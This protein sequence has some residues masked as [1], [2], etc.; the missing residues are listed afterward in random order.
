MTEKEK[1][2]FEIQQKLRNISK[3]QSDAPAIIP[4]GIFSDE[5]KKAVT[6]FQKSHNLNQTGRVDFATFEELKRENE[7]VLFRESLPVQVM[8]IR[9]EDFPIS[10]GDEN[11]F[12]EKL[13]IM[14][15]LVA[16][17]HKNFSSL[18]RNSVFDRDTE[19]QVRKW[20][21]VTFTRETG[22]VD[23]ETWNSL[24]AYYLL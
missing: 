21:A 1:V 10:Y 17:R 22:V 16:D 4:D 13:K 24:A 18:E 3:G 9:N 23:K 6:D 5:T 11:E 20:Q 19:D 2:I 14:L 8:R 15:N 7:R 12:V